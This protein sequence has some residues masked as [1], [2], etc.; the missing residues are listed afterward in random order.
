[1]NSNENKYEIINMKL[2]IR[3]Y[4]SFHLRLENTASKLHKH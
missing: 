4:L 1:M 2:Q 3:N